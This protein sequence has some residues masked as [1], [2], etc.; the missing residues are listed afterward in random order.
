MGRAYG[1]PVEQARA[2][3]WGPDVLFRVEAVQYSYV[4]DAEREEYRATD[5]KLEV[6]AFDVVKWTEHGATLDT[7]SGARRRWVDLR[8]GAK[9]WA[10]RTVDEALA[11]LAA[12]RKR[13]LY[14]LGKQVARAQ[15]EIDLCERALN[16][17]VD[18]DI[19]LPL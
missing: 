8:P 10:S 16:K 3:D 5:P 12:R 17:G 1:T 9:Q 7:W 14:I 4:A 2:K 18:A 15:R 13:Q 6:F 19:G 11:K